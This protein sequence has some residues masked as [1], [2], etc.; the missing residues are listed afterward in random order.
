MIEINNYYR[1]SES[2]RAWVDNAGVGSVRVLKRVNFREL[3]RLFKEM[4]CEMKKIS[5]DRPHMIFYISRSLNDEM[6]DNAREFLDF[7]RDCLGI[8]FEM[9]ILE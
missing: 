2:Y 7:C 3:V 8:D 1:K 6:S 5:P 9:V 4:L